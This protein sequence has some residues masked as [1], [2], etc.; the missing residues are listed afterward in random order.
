VAFDIGFQ[1]LYGYLELALADVTSPAV[2]RLELRAVDGY[3]VAAEEIRFATEESKP[4]TNI[5]DG[6]TVVATK[7]R[8]GLAEG[9]GQGNPAS[10]VAAATSLRHCDET[11]ARVVGWSGCG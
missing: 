7:V 8:N 3:Q 6:L 5:L 1:F 10:G 2:D 9:P 4:A 11:R